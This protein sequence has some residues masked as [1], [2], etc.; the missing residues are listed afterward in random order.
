MKIVAVIV[1]YNRRDCLEKLLDIYEGIYD[2]PQ[3]VI[4]VNNN[5]SDDTEKLLEKWNEKKASFNKHIINLKQNL[6]GSGG[7]YIGI[8]KALDIGADW[9]YVSDDDAFPNKNIF[10]LFNSYVNDKMTSINNIAAICGKVMNNGKVDLDHRKRIS[11]NLISIKELSVPISEYSKEY[12]E[13]DLF[14]Y[15]GTFINSKY[16]NKCG[17]TE[18]DYFIFYD[19]TE[20]SLRLSKCGKIICIPN[21]EIIHDI[22]FNGEEELSWKTYYGNRNRLLMIKKHYNKK[23]FYLECI[24]IKL[25][26]MKKKIQKQHVYHDVLCKSIKDAKTN[27]KGL[28]EVYKPG[29]KMNI[30]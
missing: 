23:Y 7:F 2:G 27:K 29:W 5:S 8:N 26:A 15:V 16:I 14:S 6:G 12:F 13:L 24:R 10:R 18:K 22:Q 28:D 1:T 17:L 11:K 30:L 19:D 25:R 20:H 3:D 21:I 4:I 9:I